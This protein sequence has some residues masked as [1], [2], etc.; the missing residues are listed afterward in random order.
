MDL[1]AFSPL[2]PNVRLLSEM[3]NKSTPNCKGVWCH[4]TVPIYNCV[5][6]I[7]ELDSY[8]GV[9]FPDFIPL[10]VNFLFNSTRLLGE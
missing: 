10:N 3:R 8:P 4:N 6:K 1:R 7:D 9:S 5:D 2:L